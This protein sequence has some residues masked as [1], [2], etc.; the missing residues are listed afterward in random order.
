MHARVDAKAGLIDF[1]NQ[2]RY[3]VLMRWGQ[4]GTGVQ[5]KYGSHAIDNT[6]GIQ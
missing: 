5:R 3:E 1:C 2:G 4:G 6:Q